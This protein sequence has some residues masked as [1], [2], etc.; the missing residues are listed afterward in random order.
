MW[1]LAQGALA[2][3]PVVFEGVDGPAAVA[4][5]AERTGLLEGE[6]EPL[7][8][9]TLLKSAPDARGEAVLRRCPSAPVEGDPVRADY[10]RSKAAFVKGDR[11]RAMDQLD[12]AVA[13]IGCLSEV[14]DRRLAARVFVLR[15]ALAATA[16]P[17]D[18]ATA[19]GEMRTAIELVRELTWDEWLPDGAKP[20]FEA[21]RAEVASA[22]DAP[23][24]QLAVVPGQTVSGPWVDGRK[25]DGAMALRP[26]LHLFQ[27]SS[28]QGIRSGWLSIGGAA[29]VVLPGQV[30]GPVMERMATAEGRALMGSLLDVSV[31]T[32]SAAYVLHDGG[33]WLVAK[34]AGLL[35]ITVVEPARDAAEPVASTDDKKRKRKKR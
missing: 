1:L 25:V 2:G 16:E 7:P 31:D 10:A 29:E 35:E 15:G 11:F 23:M 30:R 14:V 13:K 28:V 26:G 6:L 27:Y 33:L 12:L 21:V 17:A 9:G 19:R 24:A 32:L 20:L 8:L 5:V 34:D 22:D 3:V 4:A 18:E